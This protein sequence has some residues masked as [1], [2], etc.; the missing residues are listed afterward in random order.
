[1]WASNWVVVWNYTSADH[2]QSTGVFTLSWGLLLLDQAIVIILLWCSN[3][4]RSLY[5]DN[6]LSNQA[7]IS[8]HGA[9]GK[10]RQIMN[11]LSVLIK[12]AFSRWSSSYL[13]HIHVNYLLVLLSWLWCSLVHCCSLYL[14][15]WSV[16]WHVCVVGKSASELTLIAYICRTNWRLLAF[17]LG[18][19][20]LR[21]IYYLHIFVVIIVLFF[22]LLTCWKVTNY[23]VIC[24]LGS[25]KNIRVSSSCAVE[26]VIVI[27]LTQLT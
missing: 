4:Y 22:T 11:V 13:T 9:H 3:A 17:V 7:S 6:L 21:L 16:S 2:S 26:V 8:F 1:L 15:C 12:C 14:R 25:Q 23:H 24:V 19:L 5:L 27:L 20:L 18:I 10:L